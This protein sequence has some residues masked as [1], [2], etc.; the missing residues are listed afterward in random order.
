M[1]LQILLS[2]LSLSVLVETWKQGGV[3]VTNFIDEVTGDLIR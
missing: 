1:K 2:L 3:P